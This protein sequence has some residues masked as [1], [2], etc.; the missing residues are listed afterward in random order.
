MHTIEFDARTEHALNRLARQAGKNAEQLIREAVSEFLS[1][2]DDIEAANAAYTR[3]LA[4]QE[5]TVP[6]DELERRL[7]LDS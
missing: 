3:Y 6:L 4:G 2:Q 1:E 5:K 7:G